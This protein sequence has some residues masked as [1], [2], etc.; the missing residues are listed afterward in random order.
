VV[1][2]ARSDG[3]AL[4]PGG[5]LLVG[6]VRTCSSSNSRG[7][8]HGALAVAGGGAGGP[9]RAGLALRLGEAGDDKR[10][11]VG[12]GGGVGAV[13]SLADLALRAGDLLA[14]VVNVE[15]VAGVALLIAVLADAV[16]GQRPGERDL[17]LASGPLHVDREVYPPS[18]K[19]SP[20]SRPRRSS[21]AWIPAR[22][23]LSSL[24]AD[25]VATSVMT[26]GLS[27]EQVS[28]AW[29]R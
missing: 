3:V 4:V 21:R 22:A 8:A 6:A 27:S 7:E 13:S 26:L 17:V 20:G 2:D 23:R 10:G 15:V 11:G 14:V 28:V 19:C 24:V 25:M 1:L 5:I 9:H 12:R 16:A 29:A 18:A